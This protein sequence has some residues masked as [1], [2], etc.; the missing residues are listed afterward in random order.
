M[1]I[2]GVQQFSVKKHDELKRKG[3]FAIPLEPKRPEAAADFLTLAQSMPN[4]WL[5]G[6][7]CPSNLYR[8]AEI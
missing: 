7:I 1:S 3:R 6:Q 4:D 2:R 5:N 8:V